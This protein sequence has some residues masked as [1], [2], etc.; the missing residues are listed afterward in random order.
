MYDRPAVRRE[1]HEHP[2]VPHLAMFKRSPKR[3]S[4]AALGVCSLVILVGAAAVTLRQSP[5]T[6]ALPATSNGS[7]SSSSPGALIGPTREKSVSFLVLL[8]S[9]ARPTCLMRW[10]GSARLSVQ[11]SAGQRW[12]TISGAPRNVDRSFHLSIDDYRSSTGSVVFAANHPAAV[13]SGVCGE[14][15]GVGTIHSFIEPTSLAVPQGGLSS[16]DLRTAYDALPLTDQNYNGQGETVVFIE[17]GGF[18]QSDFATFAADEKLPPYNLSLVGKNTGY[19]D[20]TTMDI[21][22]VHEIAPLAHLVFFNLN[23]ITNATSDADLFAQV[24]IKAADLWPGAIFSISLGVC[25][26]NTQAFNGADLVALNATVMSIE[27]K[28]STV[29]ASSGDSGGL[30]CTPSSDD[31][32]PPQSSFVGVLVPASLP[33]VTGTGGTALTTDAAGNYIGETT[34]SEPLLSQGTG[35]GVSRYF[36]RPSWETGVGTGGQIDTGNHLEVPDVGSDSDPNTGNAIILNGQAS[37]GGGTSL[38][39]PTWA[40]FTALMDQ[41]L[42]AHHDPPVGFFNPILFHL[43]N[44]SVPYPPFH[45]TTLGGNDFYAATPGYDMTTGLGSPNVYNLARDLTAGRF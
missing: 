43:A 42:K 28:G 29:F 36:V 24:F 32:Q 35:G 12:A 26:T 10:A 21:E 9:A 8:G 39:A 22:T 41:Y 31:G 5:A 27:A 25:E 37:L 3:R 1:R 7:L 2:I 11:W 34:W 13:P 14:V 19:D 40:G 18:L 23:S 38:A 15:A 17:G 33:A 20:E 45:D 44:S 30:D 6:T 4:T 16:V